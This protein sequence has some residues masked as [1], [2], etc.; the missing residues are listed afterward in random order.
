M[1]AWLRDLRPVHIDGAIFVLIAVTMAMAITLGTDDAGKYIAPAT[2]FYLKNIV[3]WT[4][5]GFL[6]LKMFRSASYAHDVKEQQTGLTETGDPVATKTIDP[7]P[8]KA[9]GH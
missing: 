5:A 9:I 8:A 7:L 3:A 2:L 4:S 1:I 6:A